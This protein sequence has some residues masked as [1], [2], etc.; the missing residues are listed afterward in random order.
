[1]IERNYRDPLTSGSVV[2]LEKVDAAR[3]ERKYWSCR[4]VPSMLTPG[5]QAVE[6]AWGRIGT[7]GQSKVFDYPNY[8]QAGALRTAV[9][10]L[11]VKLAEGYVDRSELFA[12]MEK[13][14]KAKAAPPVLTSRTNADGWP[15]DS[16]GREVR[17][18]RAAPK[19][20]AKASFDL[21]RAMDKVREYAEPPKPEPRRA[22]VRIVEATVTERIIDFED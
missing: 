1:V 13:I 9:L 12:Y 19:A 2:Y 20:V 18:Q 16:N 8:T 5:E 3:N 17:P 10:K 15:V 21:V 14:A 7:K 22:L 11:R 6:T 4:F